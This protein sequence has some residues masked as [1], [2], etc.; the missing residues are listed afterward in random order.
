MSQR[1]LVCSISS[2]LT[3]EH[4]VGILFSQDLVLSRYIC[5]NTMLVSR[6]FSLHVGT[7]GGSENTPDVFIQVAAH[8]R[9]RLLTLG[10]CHSAAFRHNLGLFCISDR[11]FD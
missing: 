9:N 10:N 1:L 4:M 11:N 8:V 5:S 2:T 7:V 3:V 6:M